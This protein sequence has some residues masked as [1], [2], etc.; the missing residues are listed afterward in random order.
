M[1]VLEGIQL[2]FTSVDF[3][4]PLAILFPLIPQRRQLA[5]ILLSSVKVIITYEI[6][7]AKR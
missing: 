7:A 4:F 5:N 3:P 1:I 2:L 6:S